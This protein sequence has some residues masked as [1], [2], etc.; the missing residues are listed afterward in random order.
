MLNDGEGGGGTRQNAEKMR[1]K[2]E[3]HVLKILSVANLVWG[4]N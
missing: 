1:K 2:E 4:Y 3:T